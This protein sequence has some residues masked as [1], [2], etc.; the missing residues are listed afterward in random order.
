ML[1]IPRQNK[2][3]LFLTLLLK[4]I[5]S[6]PQQLWHNKPSFYHE[7]WPT[8]PLA[9]ESPILSR[10]D[11]LTYMTTRYNTIYG[12]VI[13]EI[14]TSQVFLSCAMLFMLSACGGGGGGGVISSQP[15]T[16][17]PALKYQGLTTAAPI[18]KDNAAT[19][20][21]WL[22]ADTGIY[23][24]TTST[25]Q[26][27]GLASGNL[28]LA[29]KQRRIHLK[30]TEKPAAANG[31]CSGGG[32]H[33]VV[34]QTDAQGLGI[35]TDIYTQC[36]ENGIQDDGIIVTDILATEN[37]SGPIAHQL[38]T[39]HQF[40]TTSATAVTVTDGPY[41]YTQ[42]IATQTIQ[43]IDNTVTI[44]Q[45]NNLI[46][47]NV[48]F[49]DTITPNNYTFSGRTYRSDIG[50]LDI[51][52]PIPIFFPASTNP[53]VSPLPPSGNIVAN[54]GSAN[55]RFSPLDQSHV[56][57]ELDLDGNGSYEW[58]RDD[59]IPPTA[60]S[61]NV[62]TPVLNANAATLQEI[63][64]LALDASTSTDAN[65]DFLQAT[66]TVSHAPANSQLAGTVWVGARPTNPL[67]VPGSYTFSVTVSDGIHSSAAQ[68][69]TVET[70]QRLAD[71]G[72]TV[73]NYPDVF[74]SAVKDFATDRVYWVRIDRIDNQYAESAVFGQSSVTTLESSGSPATNEISGLLVTL[75]SAGN[76]YS[77]S[78]DGIHVYTPSLSLSRTIAY[79]ANCI[80]ATPYGIPI[81]NL[82][83]GENTIAY[84]TCGSGP[85]Y[86][87]GVD[88]NTGIYINNGNYIYMSTENIGSSIFYA[89]NRFAYSS[90]LDWSD[91]A[92]GFIGGI[93]AADSME[94]PWTPIPLSDIHYTPNILWAD[95]ITHQVVTDL[96]NVYDFSSDV[97]NFEFTLPAPPYSAPFS[98]SSY[99]NMQFSQDG[100]SAVYCFGGGFP[101]IGQNQNP[102]G[103]VAVSSMQT[104]AAI[105]T[106]I[107]P[108]Q[109]K[110]GDDTPV[111]FAPLFASFDA[112]GK[113]IEVIA[114]FN[115]TYAQLRY[116]LQ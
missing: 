28:S 15:V 72:I 78:V 70:Y 87:Y 26:T 106:F 34:D 24:N 25:T 69:L 91:S 36:I 105:R 97:T 75:G 109:A 46:Y 16:I 45:T 52:T 5:F 111:A 99:W 92:G 35:I 96:G 82:L 51:T 114:Y 13:V 66:W 8:R 67:D 58:F 113:Y 49:T 57:V 79:P 31:Q 88:T 44:D 65:G 102:V 14:R 42:T 77:A 93:R 55:I 68:S 73:D 19:L 47:L 10:S 37:N 112:S 33:G 23:A 98:V 64:S 71:L 59:T 80:Q 2:A 95:A 17:P 89:A 1:R 53:S 100:Q 90:P 107:M 18:T 4:L 63:G 76:I 39:Y 22:L 83:A 6:P 61:S 27:T 43:Y 11:G 29:A 48:N 41:E 21:Q 84:M 74:R 38:I 30:S 3:F 116:S 108:S 54:N 104:G 56:L 62:N 9:A 20:G 40:K 94:S 7:N 86:V 103:A 81:L 85:S 32:T 50:Y 60:T 115:G 12:A 101:I 110:P